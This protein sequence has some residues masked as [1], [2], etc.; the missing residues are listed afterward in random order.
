MYFWVLRLK[1]LKVSEVSCK[2]LKVT[3]KTSR[4][5]VLKRVLVAARRKSSLTT[6][7][8]LRYFLTVE[9][10]RG[11]VCFLMMLIANCTGRRY[12]EG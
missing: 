5:V 9:H 4:P 10:G 8:L 6:V 2:L 3:P 11:I 12:G 7:L 1:Q